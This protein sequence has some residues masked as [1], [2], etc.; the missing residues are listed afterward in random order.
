MCPHLLKDNANNYFLIVYT[1][2]VMQWH[3]KMFEGRETG[4][5]A[6]TVFFALF[7]NCKE[8]ALS[9]HGCGCCY[10]DVLKPRPGRG[11]TGHENNN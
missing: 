9:A 3:R 8:A 4:I 7:F 1:T 5:E 6:P 2:I 11:E 10:A